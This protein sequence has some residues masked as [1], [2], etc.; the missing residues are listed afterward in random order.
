MTPQLAGFLK[1]G[2]YAVPSANLVE[3]SL[4][5]I[6]EYIR[7]CFIDPRSQTIPERRMLWAHGDDYLEV[8]S[9]HYNAAL[10][11]NSLIAPL[12]PRYLMTLDSEIDKILPTSSKIHFRSIDDEYFAT[13]LMDERTEPPRQVGLDEYAQFFV[14]HTKASHLRF[15]SSPY[16]IGIRPEWL[17]GATPFPSQ[18]LTTYFE[19]I[20]NVVE[21][22][23]RL[24]QHFERPNLVM[25]V[26]RKLEEADLTLVER[27]RVTRARQ[28]IQQSA[29]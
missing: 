12:K 23:M 21:E 3:L 13:E 16:R 27:E 7:H 1:D 22:R 2:V 18:E 17:Q 19:R 25:A 4:R 26:L 14:G 8:R 10:I 11:R 24:S 28:I 29:A 9:P 20:V 6:H 15:Y 5:H